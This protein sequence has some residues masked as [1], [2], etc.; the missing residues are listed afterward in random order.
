MELYPSP[1][2]PSYAQPAGVP[3]LGYNYPPPPGAPHDRDEGF[4]PPYDDAKLPGYGAGVGRDDKLD[5]DKVDDPFGGPSSP[6]E[7]DVTSPGGRVRRER[8]GYDV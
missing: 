3:N 8:A 6:V 2:N 5:N 7:R 4:V 1:Y